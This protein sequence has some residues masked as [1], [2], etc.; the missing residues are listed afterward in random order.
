MES[1]RKDHGQNIVDKLTKF[2]LMQL[3]TC[4]R[5]S[6]CTDYCHAFE[7]LLRPDVDPA[8][9]ARYMLSLVKRE[10]GLKS[11]LFGPKPVK[12]EELEKAAEGIYRCT[13][14]GRCTQ[15][16]PFGI[17]T[18]VLWERLRALVHD[19][20]ANPNF[21]KSVE[22]SLKE[23]KDP[24]QMGS[25]MRLF[26]TKRTKFKEAPT[27]SKA[28]TVY[29]V[30]CTSAFHHVVNRTDPYAVGRILNHIGEDWTMLG[31]KEWCCGCPS[32]MM[33][34]E[35]GARE[36]A[37]HNVQ[38]IKETGARMV[39]VSCASCYKALRWEYPKLIGQRPT[40]KVSHIVELI[41]QCLEKGK[42]KLE[43]LNLRI[44]YHDP[45]DLSRFGGVIEEPR[46]I[47]NSITTSFVEMP[48]NKED[49]RCCG[50]GGLL[51][52]IDD[53]L[54]LKSA[55]KRLRQAESITAE[56]ITSACPACKITL[57]QAA[58]NMGSKIEVLDMAELVARQLKL[59]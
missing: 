38:A 36:F 3:E 51:P 18:K 58:T 11:L 55:A 14:C 22:T 32:I 25:D 23:M 56:V 13:L 7:E 47:L 43:P 19:L 54:R 45:C 10:K 31:G 9:R 5:C 52:T 24:F 2:Q 12:K 48:D 15:A 29:F 49:T 35:E 27:K 50:G 37:S 46:Q 57:A 34:D 44:T 33:G 30:G 41:S 4:T 26:W 59:M 21:L 20:D 17:E 16:C 1:G 8:T 28:D 42:I 40:F 53:A 39:I 6:F